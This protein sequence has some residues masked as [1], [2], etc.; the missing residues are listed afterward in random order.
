MKPSWWREVYIWKACAVVGKKRGY[1]CWGGPGEGWNRRGNPT[2]IRKTRELSLPLASK[3]LK[4]I[5]VRK[6]PTKIMVRRVRIRKVLER[7]Q[8]GM[9]K[10]EK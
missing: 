6:K 4:S 1:R 7:E 9:G 2:K 10:L 8:P 3:N 5:L